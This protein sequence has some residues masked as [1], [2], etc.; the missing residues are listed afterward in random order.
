MPHAN[1]MLVIQDR[2]RDLALFVSL[3]NTRQRLGV[4]RSCKAQAVT[5]VH[6]QRLLC[7]ALAQ[8][9]QIVSAMLDLQV[10]TERIA[11]NALPTPSKRVLVVRHVMHAQQIHSHPVKVPQKQHVFATLGSRARVDP[12]VPRVVRERI[13]QSMLPFRV[14]IVHLH[15][16]RPLS[17]QHLQRVSVMLDS[18]EMT[19]A[20]AA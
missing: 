4:H 19:E 6:R 16:P 2:T 18:R 11:P 7:P 20:F 12:P 5:L 10:P 8:N 15:L 9:R 17:A 3:V 1:A 13:K 14:K